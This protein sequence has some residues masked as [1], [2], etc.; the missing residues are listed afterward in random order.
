MMAV[1][2][3]SLYGSAKIAKLKIRELTIKVR[4]KETIQLVYNLMIEK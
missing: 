1:I 2:R 3:Y 4:I